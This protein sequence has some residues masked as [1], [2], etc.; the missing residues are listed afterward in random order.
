LDN[1]LKP[2]WIQIF[3]RYTNYW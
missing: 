3:W 2:V 1:K